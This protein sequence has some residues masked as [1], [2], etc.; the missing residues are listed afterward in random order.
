VIVS[1][2]TS[3]TSICAS[4]AASSPPTIIDSV[5]SIAPSS[6]P[7]IGA[8][9]IVTPASARRS[10]TDSATV[11]EIVE[12]ST[13]GHPLAHAVDDRFRLLA[14]SQDDVF[15]VRRVGETEED[16]IAFLGDAGRG[17]AVLAAGL[18]E[19]RGRLRRAVVAD[20][21]VAGVDEVLRHRQSHDSESDESD[22]LP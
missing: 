19:L 13:T 9:S 22:R 14:R 2:I 10:A 3:S 15:D 5:P 17:A 1:P 6:P 20:D 18:D 7:E 12:W 8:S 11:G 21:P 16:D 4:R